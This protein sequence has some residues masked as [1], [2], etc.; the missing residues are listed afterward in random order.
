MPRMNG[1]E[2][3]GEVRKIQPNL[4]IILL[5]GFAESMG[6]SETGTGADAVI[7]KSATEVQYLLRTVSRL[8]RKRV[9]KKPAGGERAKAKSHSQA[10]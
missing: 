1:L 5:S 6:L 8:L 9:A 7:Q 4:S 3:I 2:L 10:V